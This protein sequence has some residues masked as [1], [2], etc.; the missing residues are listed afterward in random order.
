MDN[1]KVSDAKNGR[2]DSPHATS[3]GPPVL[4]D[5]A[6][7]RDKMENLDKAA[8]DVDDWYPL[9]P[10]AGVHKRLQRVSDDP[11][12]PARKRPR[13]KPMHPYTK[14]EDGKPQK[15]S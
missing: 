6:R 11:Q 9:P 12:P 4:P 8:I 2:P 15:M 1:Q 5:V 14:R 7:T 10:G 13:A 3:R